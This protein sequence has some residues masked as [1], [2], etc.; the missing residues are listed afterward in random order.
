MLKNEHNERLQ[1]EKLIKC[2]LQHFWR[3]SHAPCPGMCMSD[4]RLFPVMLNTVI[5][6]SENIKQQKSP[7]IMQNYQ[8]LVSSPNI[9]QTLGSF[10]NCLSQAA[11]DNWFNYFVVCTSHGT[12]NGTTSWMIEAGW[13]STI[14]ITSPHVAPLMIHSP[15]QLIANVALVGLAA[16]AMVLALATLRP[17]SSRF[18]S[19]R[20][21]DGGTLLHAYV[22]FTLHFLPLHYT[23]SHSVASNPADIMYIIFHIS[24]WFT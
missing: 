12:K 21:F 13:P 5:L 4:G 14:R 11:A 24:I 6:E 17:D 8:L 18:D 22:T 3:G 2:S 15:A 1:G 20:N 7:I 10:R 23:A 19:F 16:Y 9:P